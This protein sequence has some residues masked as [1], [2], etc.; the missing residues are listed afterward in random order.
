MPED[1]QL[2]V[3]GGGRATQQQEEAEH[4]LKDQVQQAQRHDG[5]H[6]RLLAIIN[7]RWSAAGAA[8]W[9]PAGAVARA[10]TMA[11]DIAALPP[12]E[13]A[14]AALEALVR[15]P[16][17]APGDAVCSDPRT[18]HRKCVIQGSEGAVGD[19]DRTR[20]RREP[21]PAWR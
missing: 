18:P 15:S 2:D 1:E 13:T 14:I 3:L 4:M 5:D 6:A 21:M 17:V 11:A 9:N 8:L 19:R 10:E 16:R 7:R 12:L 20:S